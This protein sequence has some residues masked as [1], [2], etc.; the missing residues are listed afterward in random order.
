MIG[1]TPILKPATEA[2]LGQ[3][4]HLFDGDLDGAHHGVTEFTHA[5]TDTASSYASDESYRIVCGRE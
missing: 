3:L 1:V 2:V 4:S 5:G